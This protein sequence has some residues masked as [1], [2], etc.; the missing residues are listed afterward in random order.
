MRRPL[1]LATD[2][3][4][5]HPDF[6]VE[7]TTL[8]DQGIG[9]RHDLKSKGR[10]FCRY[11]QEWRALSAVHT[12]CTKHNISENEMN[13]SLTLLHS[14]GA[15]EQKHASFWQFATIRL[16]HFMY[17]VRFAAPVWRQPATPYTIFI[18]VF[19]ASHIVISALLGLFV[20]M[21]LA[22]LC[23][24]QTAGIIFVYTTGLLIVSIY[25]HELAHFVCLPNHQHVRFLQQGMRCGLTHK[26]VQDTRALWVTLS[27]STTGFFVCMLTACV[28]TVI[29]QPVATLIALCI[30]LI[31]V[32]ALLPWY[33]DG[34]NLRS[35]VQ[36]KMQREAY[37]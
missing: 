13:D 31:H 36:K 37:S 27:G 23:T 30:S 3:L 12:F 14:I 7:K 15:L 29:A 25:L 16:R 8:H 17:G 10:I 1:L 9:I 4:R 6:V 2:W 33:G 5:L 11:L 34:R 24:I 22:G 20:L 32:C 28:A 26:P 21:C 19:R 35:F 18:G